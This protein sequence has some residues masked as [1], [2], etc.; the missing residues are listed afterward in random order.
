MTSIRPAAVVG[1]DVGGTFTD[2]YLVDHFGVR[3][4]KTPTTPEDPSLGVLRGL[5]D[6]GDP[7]VA[8]VVHGSTVATNAVLEGK[9]AKTAL[10]TTE[11]F[12]DVLEIGRQ[13]R[14]KLYDIWVQRPSPLVP[15]ER[16]RIDRTLSHRRRGRRS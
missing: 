13:D 1:V 11:G 9:G 7:E 15:R 6:L 5:R 16:R 14:E 8:L 12:E 10:V 2:F 3:V 4:H